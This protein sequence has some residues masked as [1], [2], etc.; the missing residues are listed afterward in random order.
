MVFGRLLFLNKYD[1]SHH[2]LGINFK[3]N[4]DAQLE[5]EIRYPKNI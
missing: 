1:D 5:S 3:Q 2:A 4:F